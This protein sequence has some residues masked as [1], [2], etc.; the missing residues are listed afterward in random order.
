M[1]NFMSYDFTVTKINLCARVTKGS[2]IHNDRPSHGL[3]FYPESASTFTFNSG[4]TVTP[5]KNTIIYLPQGSSYTVTSSEQH[6]CYA[7]NFLLADNFT[8]EPFCVCVKNPT[9]FLELFKGADR[10]FAQKQRGFMSKCKAYLYDIIYAMQHEYSLG[11]ISGDKKTVMEKAINLIHETYTSNTLTIA[12][13]AS[14]CGMTPEYFRKLFGKI[15][16]TSPLKYINELRI[17]RAK[18]LLYSGMYSIS[19]VA[20]MSGFSDTGYFSRSFKK[21]VGV[22]PTKYTQD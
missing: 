3:V 21:L 17:Q 14:L 18:E 19:E 5:G 6:L 9:W 13:L 22:S 10:Y 7:I 15:S 12:Q 1:K 2:P 16:G 8:N 4:K 11:Y 20:E